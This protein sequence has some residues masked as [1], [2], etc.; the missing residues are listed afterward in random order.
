MIL[1]EKARG[2]TILMSSHIFEEVEKTCDRTAIIKDGRIV[3]VQNM[4]AL[5]QKRRK[6]ITVRFANENAAADFAGVMTTS[7]AGDSVSVTVSDMDAFLKT[8][9]AYPVRDLTARTQSLEELFLHFYGG[10]AQ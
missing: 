2:K 7:A 5:Q 4:E 8:V 1:K 9:A 3:T 6:M 10:D